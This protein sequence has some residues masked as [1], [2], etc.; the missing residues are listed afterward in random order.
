MIIVAGEIHLKPGQRED[1][2]DLARDA[3]EKARAAEGCLDFAVSADAIE[4]D[5][6]NI[7]ERWRSI[8]TLE[9]FRGSGMD[10]GQIAMIARASVRRYA[11]EDVGSA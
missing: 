8:E 3:I 4:A 11:A 7:F 6:V 10:D 1:F 9:G 5:R 2:L